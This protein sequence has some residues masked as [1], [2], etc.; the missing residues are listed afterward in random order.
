ME[1]VEYHGIGVKLDLKD[2]SEEM[3]TELIEKVL[4]DKRYKIILLLL[5]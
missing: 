1:Q 3:F 4:H 2:I 5:V